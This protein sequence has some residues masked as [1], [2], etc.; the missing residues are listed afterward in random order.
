MTLLEELTARGLVQD[1]TH[2]EALSALL[3]KPGLVFYCGFDP[4]GPTLHAG[5]LLPLSMM[6]RLRR[7]GHRPLGLVGGSTGMIGDPTGKSEERKLLD[8]EALAA[9]FQS[10]RSQIQKLLPDIPVLNN[11]DWTGMGYLEF[12]RDVGKHITVNYMLAKESV[13]ARLE[14]REQGISY[15]EFSYMLLQ[16]WDF[17][18]L[19]RE[20]NC[21]LQIAGSDQWGNITCGI[22]LHR[23]MGGTQEL[24]GLV[25]PLLKTASGAKFGKTE[26][27]TSL[28][29]DPAKTSPYRFFQY[30]LNVEDADVEPYLKL[31]T[32]L[33]LEEI[34][35]I[36]AEHDSD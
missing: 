1:A 4:S 10:I 23:K 32:F 26:T 13:R 18:Y 3:A 12:L 36:V 15:T 29:L 33:P 19:A 17:A 8:A 34:S 28:W 16:A 27:G 31:F 35:R 14:D 21:Q 25:C 20:K 2:P 24:F 9:N 22:E 5:H 11:A 30:W 6:E 7:A